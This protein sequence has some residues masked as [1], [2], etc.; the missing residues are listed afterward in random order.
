MPLV[1]NGQLERSDPA[2]PVGRDLSLRPSLGLTRSRRR[3][4]RG[5]RT[6]TR[7]PKSSLPA[8]PRRVVA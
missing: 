5:D 6:S 3:P 8:L 2:R 7:A 1:D 4:G